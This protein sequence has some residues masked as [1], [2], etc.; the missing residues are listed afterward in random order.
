VCADAFALPF[1]ERALDAVTIAF[2]IRNLRPTRDALAELARVLRPGGMLV[3]LEATAPARGAFAPAHAFYL[4]HLVPLAGR[5]SPDPSAYVYLSTSIFE[6]GAGPEFEQALAAAGFEVVER[7]RFMMGATRLWVTRRDP[8]TGQKLTIPGPDGL[9]NARGG[10]QERVNTPIRGEAR[11]MEWR[12]WTGVQMALS[13]AIVAAL[14]WG[15]VEM[16]KFGG[17]LPLAGWQRPFAWALLVGGL[18]IFGL[19]SLLLLG[20]L[21]GPPPRR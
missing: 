12:V 16:A 6:F 1:G 14:V 3:V 19:R 13:T 9:R 21:L 11:A 4:R 20:R 18:V 15:T 2:G 17:N 8:S 10:G 7:R 5:L